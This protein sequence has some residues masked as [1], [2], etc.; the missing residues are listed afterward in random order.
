MKTQ[1]SKLKTQ[2]SKYIGRNVTIY[3]NVKIGKGSVIYDNVVIGLP[4]RDHKQG[5]LKTI[6][7]EGACIRPFTTIYAGNIIGKNLSTGQGASIR[8]DN[9]IG[10]DVSIGTNTVLEFSNK[11]EKGTR[12]HSL[13]FLEMTEIG[14]YVFIG[15]GTIFTDDPHPMNCPKYKECLGGPKIKK[16]AKIGAGCVILPGITIGENALIGAGSI[17]VSDVPQNTVFA[18]TPAKFIKNIK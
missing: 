15:P 1:N 7:G 17:V 13:C 6:I 8:E 11:I 2:N 10:D 14:E 16:L 5:E 4:S 12:I 9:I 18:G 3:P